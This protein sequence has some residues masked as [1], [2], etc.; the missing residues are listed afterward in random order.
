MP[1]RA[2]VVL[3]LALAVWPWCA[4][5][6]QAPPTPADAK[7]PTP[8]PAAPTRT[9]PAEVLRAATFLETQ[10][11][12]TGLVQNEYAKAH[13]LRGAKT[14]LA[15]WGLLEAGREPK[16]SPA[17]RRALGEL[18]KK[19]TAVRPVAMRMIAIAAWDDKR[20]ETLLQ[21]DGD[22]LATAGRDG[23]WGLLPATDAKFQP[24]NETTFWVALALDAARRRRAKIDP[25]LFD[26][27]GTHLRA[28]QRPDGSF[29]WRVWAKPQRPPRG[30]GA[31]TAGA[32][33]ALRSATPTPSKAS[34]AA[35]ARAS[36]W[37][38]K[39]M[40][41][42]TNPN[43][44]REQL[45]LWR[46]TA[47]LFVEHTAQR[48]LGGIDLWSKIGTTLRREQN[49]D[50]SWGYDA[51][52]E[53]TAMNLW[54]CT[55]ATRPMFLAK[56]RHG[57]RW[58]PF[59]RDLA[60]ACDSLG[61]RYERPIGWGVI[62]ASDI[63]VDLSGPR[64]LYLSGSGRLVLTA[65]QQLR[66]KHFLQRGGLVVSESANGDLQFTRDIKALCAKL[67]PATPLVPLPK[68][69]PLRAPTTALK[70][71]PLLTASN[72]I[73]TLWVHA[74]GGLSQ[75]LGP[76]GP[77][78]THAAFDLLAQLTAQTS[79]QLRWFTTPRHPWPKP[80]RVGTPKRTLRLA[81]LEH[82][83]NWN[84][85][86]AGLERLCWRLAR[87]KQIRLQLVPVRATH[88]RADETPVCYL[89]ATTAPKL[90]PAELTA[91]D[92]YLQSGGTLIVDAAA[93]NTSTMKW[94][95]A[96]ATRVGKL[97]TLSSDEQKLLLAMGPYL[98]P[99]VRYRASS[100]IKRSAAQHKRPPLDVARIGKRPSAIFS[101]VD[102]A[103]ALVGYPL[104]RLDAYHRDDAIALM[105]NLIANL[106][107]EQ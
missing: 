37:L 31:M 1:P 50:G 6:Q 5:A 19:P 20:A 8:P 87:D 7:T 85:E 64:M 55:R 72:S 69:A 84:P 54:L 43:K 79:D 14:A 30:S 88:L 38:A 47:G 103:S 107:P 81:R 18:A 52:I 2:V 95:Q 82:D 99:S 13:P 45:P 86:P 102:L 11:T 21:R 62:D 101:H 68:T 66:L 46:L 104:A 57:G 4:T 93:A 48:I 75:T 23:A 100:P 16:T 65:E 96:L 105:A 29:P 106:S 58:Q 22:W 9:L 98:L 89:T 39:R 76:A 83:G 92:R 41:L 53:Q 90:S 10:L 27:L 42:S 44:G 91:L 74:P 63:P 28:Q 51:D 71:L 70:T 34:E 25:K 60:H 73:R 3:L 56:I 26:A 33:V 17:L 12:K 15:V 77:N 35:I 94:F 78:K 97:D 36:A 40:S 67:L 49:P 24:D 32:I 61:Q 80:L 59:P